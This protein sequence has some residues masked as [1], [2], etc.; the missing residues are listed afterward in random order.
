LP[1]LSSPLPN[2]EISREQAKAF[3]ENYAEPLNG[4]ILYPDITDILWCEKLM[5]EYESSGSRLDDTVESIRQQNGR[6][7]IT[8][9]RV[10]NF[11]I[12]NLG[13]TLSPDSGTWD[14]RW[15]SKSLFSALS[16]MYAM[17]KAEKMG[18]RIQ[19]CQY[20][21]CN[22]VILGKKYCCPQHADAARQER[23]RAKKKKEGEENGNC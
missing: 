10:L 1:R 14:L 21:K 12:N 23:C 4:V 6:T 18:K 16:I 22:E 9:K 5:K 13:I 20:S 15:N 3:Y 7:D 2:A 8:Y 11:S 19:M 17:N